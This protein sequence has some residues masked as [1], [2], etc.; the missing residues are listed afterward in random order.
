ME[1][2]ATVCAAAAESGKAPAQ[3]AVP[4]SPPMLADAHVTVTADA[5]T[6]EQFVNVGPAACTVRVQLLLSK[7]EA[8][9]HVAVAVALPATTGT[10]FGFVAL[11]VMVAG[12]T[13]R[14]KLEASGAGVD[15]GRI[16]FGG[17]TGRPAANAA[18]NTMEKASLM[19]HDA[20]MVNVT[21]AV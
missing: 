16:L 8:A 18:S 20:L 9:V 2:P 4:P 3:L 21:V 1:P 11:K 6:Q 10:V 14:V 19:G 5:G 13:V 12:L 15:M 17:T 7:R